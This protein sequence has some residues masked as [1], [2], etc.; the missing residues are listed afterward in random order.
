[1]SQTCHRSDGFGGPTDSGVRRIRGSDGFEGLATLTRFVRG[2]NPLRRRP[3][4]APDRCSRSRT[5]AP[6]RDGA[7]AAFFKR[8]ANA[9][10]F[11]QPPHG[12]IPQSGRTCGG[13]SARPVRP[14]C[15]RGL[16]VR[17]RCARRT[18][19]LVNCT[20]PRQPEARAEDPRL[21]RA[22]RPRLARS[23][24][25]SACRRGGRPGQLCCPIPLDSGGRGR[26]EGDGADRPHA[27]EPAAPTVLPP[28]SHAV[29][30]GVSARSLRSTR[31]LPRPPWR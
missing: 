8:A 7:L 21:G 23:G 28:P 19:H 25:R 20:N 14:G 30:P 18:L 16:R 1:M 5:T 6:R 13:G 17:L 12:L 11:S 15:G 3:I 10:S 2:V 31:L 22:E 27:P 24:C 9:G 4:R 26:T 29:R